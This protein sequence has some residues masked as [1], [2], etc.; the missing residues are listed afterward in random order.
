MAVG[1]HI[2]Y[3]LKLSDTIDQ[4]FPFCIRRENDKKY[5]ILN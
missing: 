4:Y 2:N 3:V 5:C 1:V